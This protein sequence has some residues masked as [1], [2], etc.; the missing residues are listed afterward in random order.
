MIVVPF[1]GT[2]DH[3]YNKILLSVKT[4]VIHGG[5]EEVCVG[6]EPLGEVDGR[7]EDH[8]GDKQAQEPGR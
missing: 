6:A 2:P 5:F 1:V 3:H 7:G 8:G 4:E